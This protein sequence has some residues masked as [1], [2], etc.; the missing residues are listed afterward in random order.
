MVSHQAAR[1]VAGS[2]AIADAHFRA[3]REPYHP[4]H[5]PDGYLNLGTA[6]NRLVWDLL[7]ARIEASRPL[8]AADVRYAPLHGTA[9]LREAVAGYVARRWHVPADAE[10]LVLVSGATAALDIVATVLCDPGEAI[11]LPAPYYGAF[12]VDLAGRSGARLVAAPTGSAE[13]FQ[14][15]ADAV[16]AAVDRARHAGTAVRA[17]AL[18]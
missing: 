14:L 18:A 8:S 15:S 1:L 5:R 9:A 2:P 17:I 7:E 6:E 11:V 3:E 13:Q 10:D 16:A 12:D 4:R